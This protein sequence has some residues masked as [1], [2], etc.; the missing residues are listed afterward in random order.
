MG[1][2]F[3]AQSISLRVQKKFLGKLTS[4][5][6]INT[7]ID[8][9]SGRILDNLYR[10]AKD[11]SD[12]KTAEKVIKNVIKTIIKV[13]VLYRNDQFNA[14][15]LDIAEK[16]KGKFRTIIMTIV[17]FFQVDFSYDRNF[18]T[19]AMNDCCSM[20]KRLVLRHLTDKSLGRIEHVFTFF[21]DNNFLDT[22]FRP[23]GDHRDLMGKIVEDL[24]SLLENGVL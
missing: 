9:T 16:F 11:N 19:D 22:N 7:F 21:G 14:D 13:G 3:D 23:N 10:L 18:L 4:R 6:V 24:N 8:E 15:E 20:L 1:D 12:K 2:H 17:S 5:K